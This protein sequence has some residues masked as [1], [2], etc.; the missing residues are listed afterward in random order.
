MLRGLLDPE[1]CLQQVALGRMQAHRTDERAR[2]RGDGSSATT[3]VP[4]SCR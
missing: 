2:A 3:A 4:F 1:A